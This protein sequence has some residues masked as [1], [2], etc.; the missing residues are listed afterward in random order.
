[1]HIRENNVVV[2]FCLD[3]AKSDRLVTGQHSLWCPANHVGFTDK[4]KTFWGRPAVVTSD[5]IKPTLGGA[6]PIFRNLTGF[7]VELNPDNS[8]LRPGDRA[9]VPHASLRFL[10]GSY[11]LS[12]L[13]SLTTSLN[14]I[15]C[16]KFCKKSSKNEHQCSSWNNWKM[17]CRLLN[18]RFCLT[19]SQLCH[20]ESTPPSHITKS[21]LYV[22]HI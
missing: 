19:E 12:P 1:M 16:K 8:E 22:S 15:K 7:M 18:T 10:Y 14:W 9:A 21:E 11:P 20:D 3:P 13:L 5:G 2:Y 17:N 4:W 6:G